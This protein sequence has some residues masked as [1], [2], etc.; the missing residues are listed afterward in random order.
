MTT[1]LRLKTSVVA[2]VAVVGLPL[3]LAAAATAA[4]QRTAATR[5][6]AGDRVHV[7]FAEDSAIRL[8]DDTLVSLSG[9]DVSLLGAVVNSYPGL[10]IERLFSRSEEELTRE[11]ARNEQRSG[12]ELPDKTLWY[13]LIVPPGGDVGALIADLGRLAIVET[14]YVEPQAAPPPVTPSFVDDQGYLDPATDGIDAEYAW[15]IPGGT[16]ANIRVFD[17]EYSWNQAHEDLDA[18]AG[19]AV[20]IANGT[21]SDPFNSTRSRDRG[22]RRAGGDERLDRR[23][24][25]RP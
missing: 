13:R 25:H 6:S 8:S 19:S 1:R 17:I 14:T 7:K 4:E 10:S 21:P 3:A 5:A 2:V 9:A 16:G 24:G 18:A 20:L 15:T 12:R 23:H 22:A 11:K